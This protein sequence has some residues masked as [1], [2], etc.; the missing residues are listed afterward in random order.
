M[1]IRGVRSSVFSGGPLNFGLLRAASGDLM[2]GATFNLNFATGAYVGASSTDILCSRAGAANVADV[3]GNWTA[4][5]ANTPRIGN[6]GLLVEEARTNSIRNNSMQGGV[7]GSPGTPPTNAVLAG[8]LFNGLTR[9]LAYG[10]E[11]GIDY[12]DIRWTG[13]TNAQNVYLEQFDSNTQIAAATGQTWNSSFFVSLAAGTV[14]PGMSILHVVREN[15]AGGAVVLQNAAAA[16]P[17]V[18]GSLGVLRYNAT[19]TL[20]GGGTVGAVINALR[21]SYVAVPIGTVVDFTYRVG[22]PQLELGAFVTS[23]IR[24]TSAAVTRNADVVTLNNPPALGNVG[25]FFWTGVREVTQTSNHFAVALSNNSS[26]NEVSSYLAAT[27][28]GNAVMIGTGL[29]LLADSGT[30]SAN[31]V[32][33]LAY[34]WDATGIAMSHNG[35]APLSNASVS[36]AAGMNQV[37]FGSRGGSASWFGGY[38]QKAALWSSTRLPNASLVA[39]TT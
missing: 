25:T 7:A 26:A 28:G 38:L 39:L 31:V 19:V 30:V 9:S 24:T 17:L 27:G 1:P 22:W 4:V 5:A 29:T 37:R 16:V 2:A 32:Q 11:Q 6:K 21:F 23:P 34:G 36:T 8:T 35:A 33:R 12:V 20:S 18:A 3:S 15:T 10:T 13:T 14:P